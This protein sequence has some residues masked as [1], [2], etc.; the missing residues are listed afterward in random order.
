MKK[1]VYFVVTLIGMGGIWCGCSD[2]E[3]IV[4][5]EK[6]VEKVVVEQDLA[7]MS[8]TAREGLKGNPKTVTVSISNG[9]TL[10]EATGVITP[11]N[12]QSQVTYT[13]N[14]AGYK[15]NVEELVAHYTELDWEYVSWGDDFYEG[16]YWDLKTPVLKPVRTLTVTLGDDNR[17]TASTEVKYQYGLELDGNSTMIDVVEGGSQPVDD[18]WWETTS[19][20]TVVFKEKMQTKTVTTIDAVAKKATLITQIKEGDG[21]TWEDN[22][23]T[24]ADLDEYGY[25]NMNSKEEYGIEWGRTKAF[26]EEASTKYIEKLDEK[27]NWIVRYSLAWGSISSYQ[28]REIVYY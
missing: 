27:G 8:E 20:E 18:W 11:G 25:P 23:K 5:V 26:E 4:E 6:V 28:K 12:W 2:D 24:I 10:D 15:T 9:G 7:K 21:G 19:P 16:Q 1:S 13:Y 22:T 3:K 17:P 14:E